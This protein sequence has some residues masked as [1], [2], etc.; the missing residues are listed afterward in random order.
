MSFKC[1]I[2]HSIHDVWLSKHISFAEAA[3]N[4]NKEASKQ[5]VAKRARARSQPASRGRTDA[6]VI[7]LCDILTKD[8]Y[9]LISLTLIKSRGHIH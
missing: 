4:Q 5:Q 6:E 2:T 9:A 8:R 7:S 1:T 3:P